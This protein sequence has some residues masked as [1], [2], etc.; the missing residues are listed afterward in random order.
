MVHVPQWEIGDACALDRG[1][2]GRWLNE[3][4][5]VIALVSHDDGRVSGTIRFGCDGSAYKPYQLRGT[6]VVRPDGGGR[7]IVGTMPGW[8]LASALT[9]WFGELEAAGG[10]LLTKLLL[11]DADSPAVDWETATG[12][13]VF[14]R[15]VA[16]RRTA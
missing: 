11:A 14:Q 3:G 10:R 6:E 8:P 1:L 5:T 15:M 4:G 12:G 16:R 9:V 7:G 2:S 13:S